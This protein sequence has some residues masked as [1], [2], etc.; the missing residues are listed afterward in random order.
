MISI[1]IAVN[2]ALFKWQL[3]LFWHGHVEQYGLNAIQKAMPIIVD[4]GDPNSISNMPHV[5][6]KPYN[7]LY[8]SLS[9]GILRPLNIQ[10]GLS[11]VI[12]MFD[13]DQT[14]EILDCDMFHLK[15]K[16][17]IYLPENSII[18]SDIYEEWHLKSKSSNKHILSS[19][20]MSSSYYNGGFV[21]IIIKARTLKEIL[22]LWTSSHIEIVAENKDNALIQ[23]WAGMYALQVACEVHKVKMHSSD[24]LYVP[25][26]NNIN[27]NHY[28]AHYSV[29]RLFDKKTIPSEGKLG[30]VNIRN[31]PDNKFYDMVKH[32]ILKK[33]A[34]V[35]VRHHVN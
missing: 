20:V 15:P 32:W 18:V 21:P 3:E 22:P 29:D 33:Q 17:N 8:P 11:Q 12:D 23:W 27:D 19:F 34:Y 2:N 10:A 9:D 28:I 35:S 31:F 7:E 1:P 14:L 30:N 6:V 4:T 5:R 25:G 26:V 24:I 13:P 16:P